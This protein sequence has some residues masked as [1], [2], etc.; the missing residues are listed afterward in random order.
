MGL[1]D[2]CG[3][4]PPPPAFTALARGEAHV[5]VEEQQMLLVRE[6]RE[7]G[8]ALVSKQVAVDR[9][10]GTGWSYLPWFSPRV[11][12]TPGTWGRWS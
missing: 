9:G 10:S 3:S 4:N 12:W 2:L 7:V 5:V 11:E 1:T 8:L 6:E